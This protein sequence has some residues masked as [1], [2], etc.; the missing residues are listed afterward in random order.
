VASEAADAAIP[1]KPVVTYGGEPGFPVSDLQFTSSAFADPQGTGTYAK[2]QWRLA[3]ISGPGVA[4]FTPGSPRKYEI[5]SIWTSE[6]AAAPGSVTIPFGI[7]Q[8]G[9]T[10][11]VR[12]R[13]QDSSGR[14]SHWSAPAQFAATPP[15]PGELMHYWN[16]NSGGFLN[17]TQTI[18]GGTL[19]PAVSSGAEVIQH[20]AQDQGFAAINA[21]NGDPVGSHLRVNSPLGATLTFA[22]PTT[23]YENVVVQY[24]SRRS[25]QGAAI[26]NVSYTLD[27]IAFTPF[28]AIQPPDGNPTLQLLDFRA[29]PGVS[30]NPLFGLRITFTQGSG[31][32]AGNNRFDNFT[33]EGDQLE[34]VPGTYAHWRANQ[35]SGADATNDSISGPEAK[36]AGDGIA[37]IMR[38]A[39][40][41]GPYAPVLH[42][43]PRIEKDGSVREFL[44]R[45]DA[46]KTDLVWK[47]KA[48]DDLTGWTQ[49]LFDSS[50]DPIPALEDGWLPVELP[51]AGS[52]IFARLEL[53]T[54]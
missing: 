50:T 13:H 27:G 46:S 15:P 52:K 39:H 14:W 48:S 11:R 5:H 22:I 24:E 17:P 19:T 53:N 36:P 3:E 30:D 54:Q 1:Q 43:M 29:V 45:Y 7:T 42:L 38:Y 2:T 23:G 33:V 21:R 9:K 12:V 49:T 25:G 37:N 40:G 41:V 28:I 31:G 34:L 20:N 51:S 6:S 18:G 26:Q 10:Y 35:F 32:T 16:F 47:V 8:A 44:F 4:G